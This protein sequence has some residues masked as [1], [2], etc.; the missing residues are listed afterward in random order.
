MLAGA[1][2]GEHGV[3]ADDL[4]RAREHDEELIAAV[5]LA[6]DHLLL[7]EGE[8][9]G[10][11]HDTEHLALLQAREERHL[12]EHVALEGEAAGA[13]A[14]L[15][16]ALA[17]AHQDGGDVIL[18]ALAVGELDEPLRGGLAVLLVEVR[19]ELGGVGD[20]PWRPSEAR[21]NWSPGR[22]S[23]VSVSTSTRS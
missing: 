10:D 8:H 20:V 15:R 7:L 21:R 14:V 16:V 19:L 18:A 4:H 17:E 6:D 13:H 11:L 2:L 5:A 22:T 3:A 9:L 12:D 23:I 1:E